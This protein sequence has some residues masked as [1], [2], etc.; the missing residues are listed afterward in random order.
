MQSVGVSAAGSALSAIG[1]VMEVREA[2]AEAME[3]LSFETGLAMDSIKQR[4]DMTAAAQA[5]A[6]SKRLT[7]IMKL[8]EQQGATGGAQRQQFIQNPETGVFI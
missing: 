1:G 2:E 4:A 8:I 3:R 6:S 5:M 7:Q